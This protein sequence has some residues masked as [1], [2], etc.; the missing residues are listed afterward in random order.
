[1]E[2]Q[3]RFQLQSINDE[4][5]MYSIGRNVAEQNTETGAE[6]QQANNSESMFDD[7]EVNDD[8]DG[9]MAKLRKIEAQQ[10]AAK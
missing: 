8:E 5:A 4:D 1:M 2:K 3:K 9:L 6:E 10:L 7:A